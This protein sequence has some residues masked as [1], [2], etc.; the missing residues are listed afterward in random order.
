MEHLPWVDY[1]PDA[2]TVPPPGEPH[3]RPRREEASLWGGATC[4][5]EPPQGAQRPHEPLPAESPIPGHGTSSDNTVVRSHEVW[6]VA[7][8][9]C[10]TS[11]CIVC[12][13]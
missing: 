3:S 10:C 8:S 1:F 2:H 7:W 9:V 5:R 4:A 12:F 11:L 6:G 13:F